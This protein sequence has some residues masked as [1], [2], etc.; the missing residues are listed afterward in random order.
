MLARNFLC[1]AS[2]VALSSCSTVVG[3]LPMDGGVAVGENGPGVVYMLPKALVPV[4]LVGNRDTLTFQI[5]Q[6]VFVGDPAHRYFLQYEA[7]VSSSDA[8]T[9]DVDPSTGLLE[10][11]ETKAESQIDE[12][13]VELARAAGI[14]LQAAPEK[15]SPDITIMQALVDPADASSVENAEEVIRNSI[16]EYLHE[17]RGVV[18][19]DLD[20][21]VNG[22]VLEIQETSFPL[23][24]SNLAPPDCSVGVCTR[25]PVEY[26]F[27]FGF[28][29]DPQ[30]S[31][32]AYLPGTRS[33]HV[34]DFRR[35]PFIDYVQNVTFRKGMV[36]AVSLTKP[37]ELLE[38]A[39][40]PLEVAKA[41]LS[42]PGELLTLRRDAATRQAELTQAQADI[43]E[44]EAAL[45]TAEAG[46]FQGGFEEQMVLLA[47]SDASIR[48]PPPSSEDTDQQESE[49][50]TSQLGTPSPAPQ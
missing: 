23:E 27:S 38:L 32:I 7:D 25:V 47:G 4:A 21:R 5:G 40:L 37:S 18:G 41:L 35:R 50:A 26:S 44:A 14:V 15:K 12:I 34:I 10:S 48:P 3:S 28:G 16:R 9:V 42:V 24:S 20:N 6:P 19:D 13:I 17:A 22:F 36:S 43:L 8:V 11:I 39:Q 49:D 30:F 31:T 2:L 33:I 45:I 1:A 46:I 29:G